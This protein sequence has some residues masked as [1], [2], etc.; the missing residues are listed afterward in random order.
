MSLKITRTGVLD[1]IQDRGRF[2]YQHLGITTSGAMDH[3][4]AEFANA[5]LGKDLDAAVIEFHFP[6]SQLLFQSD[7]IICITGANFSPSINEAEIP[8]F[9]PVAVRR[10]SILKFRKLVSGTRSYLAILQPFDLQQWLGSYSTNLKAGAGGLKGRRLEK[11]DEIRYQPIKNIR[12]ILSTSSHQT[13]HWSAPDLRTKGNEIDFLVGHE[14]N[15][16]NTKTQTLF[17][18]EGFRITLSSDRMGYRLQGEP[19]HTDEKKQ[20]ISTAVTPGT[21]QLLPTGQLIVLMADHQTTGGYPRIGHVASSHL[22]HLAQMQPYE[23][24]KFSM[25]NI[26]TAERNYLKQQNYLHYLQKTCKL[27]MENVLDGSLRS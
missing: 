18:N 8:L 6:A 26:Q 9:H 3:F 25:T 14:W 16:L 19:I 24:I 23:T 12:K 22:S 5:I 4:S 10:G 13:L 11:G 27:K 21:I 1:T 15:W 2:G 20:L 7:T 17:L